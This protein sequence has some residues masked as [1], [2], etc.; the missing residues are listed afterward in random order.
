MIT[1]PE[2]EERIIPNHDTVSIIN[3]IYSVFLG[4]CPTEGEL[5]IHF[6]HL[7]KKEPGQIAETVLKQ[8]NSANVKQ[9]F[10]GGYHPELCLGSSEARQIP[11]T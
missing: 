1:S 4:R 7:D 11:E 8:T 5:S 9:I 6:E 10:R 2:F 3:R